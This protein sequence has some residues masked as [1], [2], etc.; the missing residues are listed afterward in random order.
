MVLRLVLMGVSGSGKSS[1]GAALSQR[2]DAPYLDGDDLHPPANVE[3]MRRGIPLTDDDRRPWLKLVSAALHDQAP[4]IVGCSALKRAYRDLLREGAG[5]A[6][7]FVHLAGERDLI[8]GR[9]QARSGHYMPPALLDSQFAAL[10]PPG[11]DEGAL[12]VDIVHPYERLAAEVTDW[13]SG[14]LRS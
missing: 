9:M 1:M 3:K 6:V 5:G 4:V 2:L 13:L 11:P 12:T 10:E 7:H 14:R 8:L